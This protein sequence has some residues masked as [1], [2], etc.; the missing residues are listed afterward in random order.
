MGN[1]LNRSFDKSFPLQRPSVLE[2]KPYSKEDVIAPGQELV[3][4]DTE[5]L[6]LIVDVI[7]H[8]VLEKLIDQGKITLGAIKPNAHESRLGINNDAKAEEA[9][10][11]YIGKRE[12]L[13]LD[14][15]F[16]VSLKPSREELELFYKEVKGKLQSIP[17][18]GK[19]VWDEVIS[20]MDSGPVT[21]FLLYSPSGDAVEQWRKIIG[22]TDP[23]KADG[24]S[25]R[26]KFALGMPNNLVHG[27]SGDTKEEAVS[28]V[29]Y[30]VHWLR[31]RINDIAKKT[32]T[33]I[34]K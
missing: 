15:M 30:E 21:Y 33:Q 13:N 1:E 32:D 9:L 26:G 11:D 6:N 22:S 5:R 17:K 7:N 34:H 27:S 10:L 28:N 18:N 2:R 25:I 24:E 12:D 14:I 29:R 20:S 23:A 4:L 16:A 8:P 3:A 19:T 31:D